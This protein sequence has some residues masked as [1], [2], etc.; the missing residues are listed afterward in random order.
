MSSSSSNLMFSMYRRPVTSSTKASFVR[1]VVRLD[2]DLLN[3]VRVM[4]E[5]VFDGLRR[6]REEHPAYDALVTAT[7]V[8]NGDGLAHELRVIGEVDGEWVTESGRFD[9]PAILAHWAER[10]DG[11]A[12]V[13][14]TVNPCRFSSTHILKR[15]RATSDKAI[16]R[17]GDQHGD[18]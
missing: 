12:D 7:A 5:S 13:Y 17:T 15:G 6:T 18:R 8:M 14:M 16:Q 10:C 3:T 1:L 2:V 4:G 11:R 9:T